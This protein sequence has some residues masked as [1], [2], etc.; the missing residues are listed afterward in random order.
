MSGVHNDVI[1]Y[2]SKTAIDAFSD[3]ATV[4]GIVL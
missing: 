1:R 2:F 4:I 3:F